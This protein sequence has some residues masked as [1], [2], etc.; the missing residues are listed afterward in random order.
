MIDYNKYLKVFIEEKEGVIEIGAFIKEDT[1][2]WVVVDICNEL[3]ADWD[4]KKN[5]VTLMKVFDLK[6]IPNGFFPL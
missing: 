3:G 1:P 4:Y 6:A 5:S 2:L